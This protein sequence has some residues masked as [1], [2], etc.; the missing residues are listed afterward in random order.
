VSF[1]LHTVTS[2]G[3]AADIPFTVSV[4]ST[5]Q[6]SDPIGPDNYGYYLYDKNDTLYA[7][8]PIYNW[9]EIA[10]GL[11]GE[12]TR[13]NWGSEYDDNSVLVVLPFDLVYYGQHY[14]SIIVCT[15]GF[16]SP[17]TSR[18]DMRGNY[19][20][21][22]FNWSIPD[23]GNCRAQISPFWDD[24]MVSNSGNN[25][26]FIWNDTTQHRFVIE[27]NHTTN[28]NTGAIETFELVIYDPQYHPTLTGDSEILYQYSVIVNNDAGE[29]YA[30]VGMESWDELT[31]IEYTHDGYYSSGASTLSNGMA[32]L[33]TT[34]TG[35]GGI[36]GQVRAGEGE[37]LAG[38]KVSVSSGQ[39]RISSATG[40]YWI[41]NVP[42]DTVSV[43]VEAGGYFPQ[44]MDSIAVNANQT[45][46][47][48]NFLL[49]ECPIP[50][51]LI[52]TDSLDHQI[53]VSW[54]A[55]VN[56]QLVGYNIYRS[57]FNSGAFTKLNAAP[58]TNPFYIDA[59]PETTLYWYYATAVF[60][61]GSWTAES[62]TS[63]TD[64][65]RRLQPVGIDEGTSIPASF[66]LSQNY[67]NPFNPTT[68]ISY[69]LPNDSDVRV[70]IFNLLGQR[71]IT[72]V[73]E[74]QNAGFKSVVWDGRDG[75]GKTVSSG[76]YFY[77]IDAG[78]FHE[79]KK[80][81]MLK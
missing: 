26:V 56:P 8:H 23:P 66:F 58:L 80:M 3:A 19:W 50:S 72:L 48:L 62:F 54:N 64:S 76:V 14:G 17:D 70:D 22:F 71:I 79:S 33:I 68:T 45:I 78:S 53:Q 6:S 40:D 39:Y 49:S 28:L 52:A 18:M 59:P 11:G 10:P 55:V 38:A 36:R 43:L 67:P 65:G 41:T 37:S 34:N 30:T 12:G 69:G 1:K 51:I 57:R 15:N 60:S 24:L 32:I 61:N 75:A 47:D 63:N 31:G 21:Y 16:I 73:N 29:N 9:I 7:P 42:P 35:R 46:S 4:D 20:S 44:S 77:K 2:T 74:H 25:G 13:L 81:V 5:L 27:W